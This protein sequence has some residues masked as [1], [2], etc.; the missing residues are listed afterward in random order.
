MTADQIEKMLRHRAANLNDKLFGKSRPMLTYKGKQ[1]K[2][3]TVGV[4]RTD[5]T[6][7]DMR[8]S[9]P[10][11]RGEAMQLARSRIVD[12]RFKIKTCRHTSTELELE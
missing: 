2:V 3:W 1:C 10:N 12:K 11:N 8:V 7:F 5:G 4:A 9:G 6:K